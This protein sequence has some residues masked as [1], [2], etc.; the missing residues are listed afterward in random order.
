MVLSLNILFLTLKRRYVYLS[1]RVTGFKQRLMLSNFKDLSGHSCIHTFSTVTMC[2][3]SVSFP[4]EPFVY[5]TRASQRIHRAS[6]A[7]SFLAI[8][9]ARVHIDESFCRT[10]HNFSAVY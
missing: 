2:L 3:D 7:L 4:I 10:S 8:H 5:E 6:S 9:V 1:I